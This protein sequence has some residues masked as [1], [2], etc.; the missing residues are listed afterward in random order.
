MNIAGALKDESTQYEEARSRQGIYRLLARLYAKEIDRHLLAQFERNDFLTA[1]RS[2]GLEISP[3][4]DT[5]TWLEQLAIEYTH[6][7]IGPGA[8]ISPHESVQAPK[9]NKLL[10]N[11]RTAMVRRFIGVTGFSFEASF[12]AYPDHI[13]AEFEFMDAL[14]GCQLRGLDEDDKKEVT[15]SLMLQHEF[16][17]RH[18]AVWLSTFCQR[19]MESSRNLF[20]TSLAG[21]TKQ[22]SEMEKDYFENGQLLEN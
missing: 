11:E 7:F 6:L 16:M 15:S 8:H 20:Y 12:S 5:Q 19:V 13:S 22:F 21:V 14:I 3:S 18:I 17:D 2:M 4:Q 1:L 9:G 10:N